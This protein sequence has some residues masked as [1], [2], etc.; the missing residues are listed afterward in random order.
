MIASICGACLSIWA[1]LAPSFGQFVAARVLSSFFYAAPE[2]LG[3]QIVTDVFFLHQR[4]T[5]TSAFT[6]FQ[7][8]GFSLA[9][10][11]GGYATLNQGWRAPSW[12]M[13]IMTYI[14]FIGMTI[15]MPETNY[16][17]AGRVT[18]GRKRGI[19][20]IVSVRPASGGGGSKVKSKRH[21]F[22]QP[23]YHLPHPVV[24]LTTSYFSI[25]LATN[26]YMLT[27]NPVSFPTSYGWDLSN[28]ALSSFAPSLG[29]I[30]GVIYGGLINDKVRRSFPCQ[31]HSLTRL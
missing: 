17:R 24:L 4:A 9:G 16:T 20:D 2:A 5:A 22:L 18:P 30:V 26:D 10:L 6:L 28:L 8:L 11:I 15:M 14:A 3:P 29:N 19:A 31:A 13:V 25:Y 27:T 23:W 7:F 1:A 21:A 12:V